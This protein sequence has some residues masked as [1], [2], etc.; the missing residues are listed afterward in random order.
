M[1]RIRYI[2]FFLAVISLDVHAEANSHRNFQIDLRFGTDF[3]ISNWFRETNFFPAL[4]VDYGIFK[5]LRVGAEIIL[6][7]LISWKADRY[8]PLTNK[9][10]SEST[11]GGEGGIIVAK[12]KTPF[13]IETKIGLFVPY[14]AI[15]LGFE[16]GGGIAFITG[17]SSG[18]NY[19]FIKNFGISLDAGSVLGGNNNFVTAGFTASLGIIFSI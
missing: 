8:D 1:Q 7:Y 16:V 5:H 18:L 13:P 19:F 3:G 2:L 9:V 14:I 4:A 11:F 10:K 12:I 17:L 6:P 15:P